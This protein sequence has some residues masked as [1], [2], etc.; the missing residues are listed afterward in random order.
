MVTRLVAIARAARQAY[1]KRGVQLQDLVK[2]LYYRK[3]ALSTE[4]KR[5]LKRARVL[6]QLFGDTQ[7]ID[8]SAHTNDC[9]ERTHVRDTRD[10]KCAYR[11][12]LGGRWSDASAQCHSTHVFGKMATEP[13]GPAKCPGS[14]PSGA[15]PATPRVASGT[16]G[17]I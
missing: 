2:L 13:G 10:G 15:L 11:A 12:P 6:A 17:L 1:T 16:F 5:D 7:V 8:A 3:W 14:L 4:S 9:C